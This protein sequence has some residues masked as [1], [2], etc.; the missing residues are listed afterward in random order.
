MVTT[1]ADRSSAA[2]A[3]RTPSVLAVLVARNA[4]RW[5]RECL[6]SLASQTHPRL[7]VLAVDNGSTDGTR[8]ILLQALGEARVVALEGNRG[9]AGAL[10]AAV[11]IPAARRADYVLVLHDDVALA[12]DAVARL[13]EAAEGLAGVERVGLV[14][15]KVVDWED[16]RL[17]RDVGCSTDRFGHPYSPLQDG[18]L[19]QGQYDRVLEVLFVP[20][21]AMLISRET[22]QR[23]GAFD[24][25]YAGHHDDL[26]FCWRARLAGFRVLM[27]PL[28]V[29]RHRDATMRGEREKHRHRSSRYY[30]ERAGLASMLK[31]Y[32]IPTLLWLL[33]VYLVLGLARLVFLALSRRFED[34]LDLLTAWAWNLLHLPGTLRRR[35]RAQSVRSVRDRAVRRFMAATFRLPRWFERAEEFLDEGFEE[36]EAVEEGRPLSRRAASV[37]IGHPVLVASTIAIV[38]GALAVRHFVGPEVLTGG[39]L[40]RFPAVADGFFRELFSGVRTT[41][42]GG[43]QPASPAL[44]ALGAVSWISF[45]STALAEKVVLGALPPL[46]AILMYRTLARQTSR[47]GS[48]VVAAGA[49]ALSG[50]S[51]WA[52]SEGRIPILVGLVVLPV[53]WDRLDWAF[54]RRGPERPFRFGVGFGVAI[55][56]GIGLEAGMLLPLALMAAAHVLAGRRRDRGLALSL[57]AAGA[58]ALLAFPV[59]ADLAAAPA[60]TLSSRIGTTDAWSVLRLAPAGGPGTWAPASFLPLAAVLCFAAVGREHRGRAWRAMVVAL[61]GLG[62]AWASASGYLPQVLSNAPAYL[63]G[64]AV[65]MAAIVAYGTSTLFPELERQAFGARQLGAALLTLVLGVGLG[66]QSLQVM[67]AEWEVRPNGLPPAWPVIDASA[68]GEFRI[69]WVGAPTGERLPAPA[70]DPQGVL[71]AGD[72]SVRFAITDRF[73]VTALDTGRAAFGPGYVYVRRALDELL[74]GETGHAGALLAPLGVRFV[75]AEEG[76]L[77]SAALRRLDEQVDLGRI[78]AGGLAIYRNARALPTA[79]VPTE[80]GWPGA[81]RDGDLVS[82]AERAPAA[83]DRL[84]P[85]EAGS[86]G[87]AEVAAELVLADQLDEGWRVQSGD[88]RVAPSLAF[89]WAMA[90]PVEP[91]PVSV[92]YTRQWTRTVE[93]AMLGLLWLGALWI[94]RKPGSA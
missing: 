6:Q 47:P 66:A 57:L 94:T 93:V 75:V 42:L 22:W 10:R 18:E 26:D 31:D 67:L 53:A 50:F 37:A 32:G 23:T 30:A 13:V 46:A 88:A 40:A 89:G 34:A 92:E 27:T 82:I 35:V 16:P 68:P 81:P 70:G 61:S 80:P 8:E 7:G 63:A 11:E 90:A 76:D 20:S 38:L 14:G 39:A 5:V 54:A 48:A 71:E 79:F 52:F 36:L 19:D 21:C 9:L 2:D 24:E 72:A 29:A 3:V 83:V 65:A 74:S 59:V 51:L 12:P 55:A 28:A 91:G 78:P 56:I 17:L 4:S 43:A 15:P 62:L 77:P 60:A 25:R 45:G 64:A 44:A 85:P 1:T 58:A 87:R 86:R 69:L 41:I 84:P 49:Y 33:P 73:G